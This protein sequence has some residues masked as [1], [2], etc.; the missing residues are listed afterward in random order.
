[1]KKLI[2]SALLAIV[3]VGGALSVNAQ[4]LSGATSKI[5][6][7]FVHTPSCSA[8]IGRPLTTQVFANP[9]PNQGPAIGVV[10]DYFY[11]L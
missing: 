4:Y 10:G 3:A 2:S 7:D 11:N 6:C 5:P 1:M 8:G 9:S